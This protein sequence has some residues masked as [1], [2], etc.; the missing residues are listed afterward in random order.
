M[1]SVVQLSHL[2][3]LRASAG[4]GCS[5]ILAG[6][7]EKCGIMEI[8]YKLHLFVCLFVRPDKKDWTSPSVQSVSCWT[9]SQS[10]IRMSDQFYVNLLSNASSKIFHDN[11]L[12][13]FTVLLSQQILLNE[14]YEVALEEFKF[15]FSIKNVT[16]PSNE[17]Y[18]VR[19][20]DAE[21]WNSRKRIRISAKQYVLL[22]VRSELRELLGA[23][24]R[25]NRKKKKTFI[26]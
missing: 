22:L 23:K 5:S 15:L 14:P 26:P 12:S 20:M 25:L 4:R 16:K 17:I 19:P 3:N 18:L 2:S 13:K 7:C 10:V 9:S 24:A 6:H 21:N 1:F 11:A 8:N